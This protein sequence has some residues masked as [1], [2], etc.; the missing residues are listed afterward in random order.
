MQ[1]DRRQWT[2]MF[3]AA[4]VWPFASELLA[5]AAVRPGPLNGSFSL[6]TPNAAQRRFDSICEGSAFELM[7]RV[8]LLA[9]RDANTL[10]PPSV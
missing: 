10:L 8:V 2:K 5:D 7:L 9:L 1:L 6:F 4:A 3:G